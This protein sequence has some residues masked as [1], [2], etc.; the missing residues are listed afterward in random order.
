MSEKQEEDE[1]LLLAACFTDEL[2]EV[3]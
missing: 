2:M 3:V 1:L